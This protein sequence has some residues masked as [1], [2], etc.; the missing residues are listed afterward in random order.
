MATPAFT[1]VCI[2]K[3]LI[4]RD[5]F[6]LRFSKP[7]EFL[8]TPGQFVLLDVPLAGNPADVQARAYSIASTPVESDLLFVVKVVPGGRASTWVANTVAPGVEATMRGPLGAFALDRHSVKDRLFLCTSTGIAPFRSQILSALA[9]GDTRRMDVILGART[10]QDLFWREEFERIAEQY[11]NVSL[12]V[13][14]DEADAKWSG[15]RGRV[16]GL[17]E[18]VIT[19]LPR[20]SV[21]LCGNP[22]MVRAVKEC[23]LMKWGIPKADIHAEAY[24]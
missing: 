20:R 18:Q 4:A 22:A 11:P 15:Y 17:A 13:A 24:V 2:G 21:Y 12:S 19:D 16:Q 9:E 8:F 14:L 6:E 5:V 10:Q 1:I 23:C 3:K 7:D